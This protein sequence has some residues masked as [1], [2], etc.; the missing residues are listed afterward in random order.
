[1]I[2][3]LGATCEGVEMAF[4]IG[5]MIGTMVGFFMGFLICWVFTHKIIMCIEEEN[6]PSG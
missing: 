1:M 3:T 4:Y 2:S 5:I 6:A